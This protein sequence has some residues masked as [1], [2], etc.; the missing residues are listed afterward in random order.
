MLDNFF[1]EEGNNNYLLIIY[2]YFQEWC[3]YCDLFYMIRYCI[4]IDFIKK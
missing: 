3:Y 1:F 2:I 4:F